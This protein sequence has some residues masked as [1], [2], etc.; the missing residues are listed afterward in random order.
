MASGTHIKDGSLRVHSMEETFIHGIF[1]ATHS[2]CETITSDLQR[3]FQLFVLMAMEMPPS[4]P[5]TI[6]LSSQVR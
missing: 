2:Q 4:A 5:G 6:K 1:M 3:N